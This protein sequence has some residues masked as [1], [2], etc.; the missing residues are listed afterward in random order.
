MLHAGREMSFPQTT[1][2]LPSQ[3]GIVSGPGQHVT[4]Y[5][6][7]DAGSDE[8]HVIVRID[9]QFWEEGGGGA[10]GAGEVHRM[11]NVSSTYLGSFNLILHPQ[12]L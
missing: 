10:S 1:Q 4:L 3:P 7:T 11:R 6:R 8:D 9:G 2:T 5:D 12:G